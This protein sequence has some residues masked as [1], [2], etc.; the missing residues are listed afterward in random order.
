MGLD[1]LTLYV[2]GRCILANIGVVDK[3]ESRRIGVEMRIVKLSAALLYGVLLLAQ[4]ERGN[5]A[6]VV[7]DSTG[8]VVP[9]ASVVITSHATNIPES[10]TTNGA[11]S[12]TAPN[13]AP[14]S[15]R[16][17]VSA[18]GFKRFVVDDVTLSAGGA[19]RVDA[20]LEVGAVGES[21]EVKASAAQLQTENAKISTA[22]QNKLVDELP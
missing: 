18:L 22:V 8:A 16:V 1:E 6:G 9:N 7:T 4:S 11:G 19:A 10:V 20:R 5:I 3:M 12:Y 17:A 15:Y 14:G 21:V 2:R 13:L